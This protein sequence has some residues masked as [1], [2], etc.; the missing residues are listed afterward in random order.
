MPEK[1]NP[2]QEHHT[3]YINRAH[4]RFEERQRNRYLSRHVGRFDAIHKTFHAEI[5]QW[6]DI[7]RNNPKVDVKPESSFLQAVQGVARIFGI[8]SQLLLY[9]PA[10]YRAT[11]ILPRAASAIKQFSDSIEVARQD[12]HLQINTEE[13]VYKTAVNGVSLQDIE[14]MELPLE[15]DSIRRINRFMRRTRFSK[16]VFP[17]VLAQEVGMFL[18]TQV[19]A[20]PTEAKLPE[21]VRPL[22]ER[23][24]SYFDRYVPFIT[25]EGDEYEKTLFLMTAAWAGARFSQALAN[26]IPARLGLTPASVSKMLY[27][28]RLLSDWEYAPLTA[29]MLPEVAEAY[30][31]DGLPKKLEPYQ[32]Y[33]EDADKK[34]HALLVEHYGKQDPEVLAQGLEQQDQLF[35]R[36]R[37]YQRALR[38][39]AS[40]SPD[41]TLG[42]SVQNSPIKEILLASHARQNLIFVLLFVDNQTHLTLEVNG[43]DRLYGLPPTL[44]RD[45]PSVGD[46]LTKDILEAVLNNASE[47]HPE[48]AG[49]RQP[50]ERVV[51]PFNPPQ[52]RIITEEE[53]KMEMQKPSKRRKVPALV[54]E[55]PE[56]PKVSGEY[57]KPTY[58]V[59]HSRSEIR[60][61]F[62]KKVSEEEVD[63]IMENIKSFELGQKGVK[64]LEEIPGCLILRI[65]KRRL[66]LE[67]RGGGNVY[68]IHK[69]GH[70]REIYGRL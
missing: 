20:R 6:L 56:L 53:E 35:D 27:E 44:I 49:L 50:R 28:Q 32:H 23:L 24:V 18:P 3:E 36:F 68:S 38:T 15:D 43:R 2:F 34:A 46:V 52:P 42:I 21:D 39:D 19:L 40:R 1:P 14:N 29:L 70:R 41:R 59:I 22:H 4:R 63:R 33:N 11:P 10:V 61:Y 67:P 55:E 60:K 48:I 51:I 7:E 25:G 69:L 58:H 5:Q 17:Q 16:L 8:K 37:L 13:D 31:K 64:L 62:G 65:G 12:P 54:L 66:I 47:R 30:T 57:K 26:F 45:N 9:A